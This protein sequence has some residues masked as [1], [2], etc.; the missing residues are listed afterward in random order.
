ME[1]LFIMIK[2]KNNIT[3]MFKCK[4]NKYNVIYKKQMIIK[5]NYMIL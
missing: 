4:I 2:D 3:K 1:Q 5:I